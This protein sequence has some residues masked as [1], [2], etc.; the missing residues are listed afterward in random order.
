MG[1]TVEVSKRLNR[2]DYLFNINSIF[3]FA[4]VHTRVPGSAPEAQ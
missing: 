4:R 1:T 2:S 3:I